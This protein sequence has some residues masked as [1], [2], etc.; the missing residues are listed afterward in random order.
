MSGGPFPFRRTA[1]QFEGRGGRHA[2]RLP[3]A[4]RH[5]PDFLDAGPLRRVDDLD[6]V[7]VAKRFR[8]GDEHRL[9]LALGEDV[10]Q[11]ALELL[12]RDIL[13]VDRDAAIGRVVEQDLADVRLSVW[14]ADLVSTGRLMSTPR[15]VRFNAA[16]KMT[17]S[18]S[19]TSMSGVTFISALACERLCPYD[20]V[21]AEM[22]VVCHYRPPAAL[23]GSCFGS[24][25]SPMSSIPA[26]RSS[27]IASMTVP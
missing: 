18:T 24:V 8:A 27:S 10:A 14:F 9:V 6:D 23:F 26:S 12:D 7:A 19:S 21:G 20:L 13:L 16:M 17:S 4:G 22:M 1:D 11:P 5:D 25:I 15:C 3:H 2:R